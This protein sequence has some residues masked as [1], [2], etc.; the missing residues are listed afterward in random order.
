MELSFRGQ[1]AHFHM[2]YDSKFDHAM[3][4]IHGGVVATI[5]DNAGWFAAALHYDY[6]IATSNLNVSYVKQASQS[7]LFAVGRTVKSGRSLAYTYMEVRDDCGD[8]VAF[9]TASFAV[10]NK[11]F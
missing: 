4:G 6:W 10:S 1:E 11:K 2:R 7:D 8:L 3:Q 9:A 5:L